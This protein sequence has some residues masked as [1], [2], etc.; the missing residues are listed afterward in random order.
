MR[1][2]SLNDKGAVTDTY[3]CY[4]V[5]G[6]AIVDNEGDIDAVPGSASAAKWKKCVQRCV[7]GWFASLGILRDQARHTLLCY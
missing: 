3:E 2:M 4:S 6:G 1:F 7:M 5:G